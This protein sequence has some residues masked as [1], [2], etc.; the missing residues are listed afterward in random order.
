[1]KNIYKKIVVLVLSTLMIFSTVSL[2]GCQNKDDTDEI[3]ITDMMGREVSLTPSKDLKVV[4]IGAGAL[5]LF[6]YVGNTK[7]LVGVEDIDNES[8]ESRPKMFDGVARPYFIAYK[9]DFKGL[10]SCG[11]GGP[12]SQTI[13]TEKILACNP[14]IIISEYGDVA[15]ADNL[16]NTIKKPVVCLSYGNNGVFDAK[17]KES[18]LLLGKIFKEEKA[19]TL[20]DYINSS[21]NEFKDAVKDVENSEKKVYICGLGNW[22]T[23]DHL[24]T[25]QNYFAFNVL[26][27]D[28]VI[29]DLAKDGIQKIE[30]E[31]LI[32]LAPTIDVLILDAAAIKNMKSIYRD[33]PTF[34]DSIKAVQDGEVYLQMAYNAYY[35][36]LEIQLINTWFYG[37][38]IYPEL[39]DI[40]IEEKAN[41]VTNKFLGKELYNEIKNYPMSYGG[42]RKIDIKEILAE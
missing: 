9:D 30:Y 3:T 7:N 23:T 1:M 36:N 15:N 18:I 11:V 21:E 16:Q 24:M 20:V 5:R 12:Q 4:C 22:G 25:V 41:E 32:S 40:D 17:A 42:Y 29:I 38:I 35:T 14:D 13:E 19:E 2:F 39:F 27:I 8:I 28:N 33:N 26:K 10:K 37:K 31:K 6:T 34:L